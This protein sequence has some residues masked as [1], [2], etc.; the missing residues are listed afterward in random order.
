MAEAWSA[1]LEFRYSSLIFMAIGIVA[2]VVFYRVVTRRMRRYAVQRAHKAQNV[3]TFFFVWRY[4]FMFLS[5]VLLLLLFGDA[6]ST[7]GITLVFASSILSWAL[8]NPI[9][10]LA[11]WL[12]VILRKPYR[13]GDRVILGGMIG[14]VKDI[15]V[16]YTLL[17]Q[18]GGTV[19]GEEKSGRSLLVPNQ[20]LFHWTIINNGQYWCHYR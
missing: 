7:L 4:M 2:A 1:F 6:L 3:L 5:V 17:E 14:D 16:N 20:H 10:N 12:M 19:G 8:R 11:A 13:V 9:M 18:V 15:S